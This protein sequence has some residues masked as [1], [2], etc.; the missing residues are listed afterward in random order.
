MY[1][2]QAI[3]IILVR[4][5]PDIWTEWKKKQPTEKVQMKWSVE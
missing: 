1:Y 2:S 4:V 5:Q 3:Y